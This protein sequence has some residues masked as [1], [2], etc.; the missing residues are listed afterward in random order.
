MTAVDDFL[1]TET[2]PARPE[3]DRDRF[4]RYLMPHPKTGKKQPWTRATTWAKTCADTFGLTKWQLRMAAVGLARRPDLLAQVAAVADPDNRDG[5]RTLDRLADE[6]MEFAG[7]S[8][9]ANLGSSLHSFTE[10]VDLGVDVTAPPQFAAD[11][12]AY[13][14]ATAGLTIDPSHVE[15]IVCIPDLG[16]A[17]TFDRLATIDG[18]LYVADLK[19]GRDLSYSWGEIA[20]QLALYAHAATIWDQVSCEHLPMPAVDQHWAVVIHLPAGEGRATLHKVDISE[21]W[22]MAQTCGVVREWRK[23]R[24]LAVPLDLGA[25]LDGLPANPEFDVDEPA[26][27][28]EDRSSWLRGRIQVLA[29]IDGAK[30]WVAQHWPGGVSGHAPWTAGECDRIAEVLSGA[31][32]RFQAPFPD[33]PPAQAEPAEAVAEPLLPPPL[34][35]AA[36]SDG[37]P[38]DEADIDALKA[39]VASLDAEQRAAAKQWAHEARKAHRGFDTF[40]DLRTRT[41]AVAVACMRCAADLYD[42]AEPDTL[43]RAALATVL[44]TP[45]HDTWTTGALLGTLT[46]TR[47]EKLAAIAEAFAAGDPETT[48]LLG[49]Q[50]AAQPGDEAQTT[51]S[52]EIRTA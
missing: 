46:K 44:D 21:G 9:R 7:R 34:P 40:A 42:P 41:L 29:G 4:G 45:V 3:P 23:R 25:A 18:R 49:A 50:I 11:L 36:R 13:R 24:D 39:L 5:K 51:E 35:K 6:A 10:Q 16:V 48:R 19:T 47:A 15:R 43:T 8:V 14:A 27:I 2:A 33:D 26:A 22:K 32:Q 52:Q 1:A 31:E 30:R 20:I 38:V 28:D 37:A 17:G 12:D